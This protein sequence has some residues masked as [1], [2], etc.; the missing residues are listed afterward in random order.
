MRQGRAG[1]WSG[2]ATRSDR[3]LDCPLH[4]PDP[5][6]GC[7]SDRNGLVFLGLFAAFSNRKG[8]FACS[9]TVPANGNRRQLWLAFNAAGTLSSAAFLYEMREP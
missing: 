5:M 8:L 7:V 2:V 1:T 9:L 6:L 3:C 4:S